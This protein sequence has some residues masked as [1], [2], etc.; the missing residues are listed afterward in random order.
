MTP[1]TCENCGRPALGFWGDSPT[2][3]RCRTEGDWR[4]LHPDPVP[5]DRE[6]LS[7]TEAAQ[8]LGVSVDTLER[9]ILNVR[10]GLPTVSVGGRVLI[11]RDA[12]KA[13]LNRK[14]R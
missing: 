5:A 10:D 7:K 12:V 9:R 3:G 13:W 4:S 11:P 6:A 14:A 8:I 2:C 1:V